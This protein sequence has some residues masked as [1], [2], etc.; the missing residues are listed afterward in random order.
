MNTTRTISELVTVLAL[1]CAPAVNAQQTT[2]AASSQSTM[3]LG[4]KLFVGVNGGAQTRSSSTSNDFSFPLYRE[5]ATVSTT[6]SVD[7]GPIFDLNVGYRFMPK[8]GVAIGY[9]S[10]NSTGTA[11]GTASIP[12]PLFFNR[13]ASVAINAVDAKRTERNIYLVVVGFVPITDEV[14]LSVF[15]GPSGTRVKQ[16]L[17]SSVTVPATTQNVVSTVQTESGTVKSVNIGAD[18]AYYFLKNLGAGFFLR[19]NGGS[20][21]LATLKGVKA[22]GFQTG[23]GA[24]LRF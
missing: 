13:P 17:I 3:P 15:V 24:R 4:G 18:I 5:T 10:F 11:Q 2:P 20:V 21:D 12:N 22:G 16:E 23:V 14:E 19:Y 7:G 9:S 8:I 1:A 6:A